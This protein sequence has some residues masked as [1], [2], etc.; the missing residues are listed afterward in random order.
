MRTLKFNLLKFLPTL[1]CASECMYLVMLTVMHME[2]SEDNLQKESVL[3]FLN[4]G[5][6]N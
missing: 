6:R 5:F 2:R 3:Y 1:L 4:V